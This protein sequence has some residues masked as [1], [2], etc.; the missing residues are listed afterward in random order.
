MWFFVT[1][2]DHSGSIPVSVKKSI[3]IWATSWQNQQNDCASSEDSDQS[4]QS[5]RCL[6]A[7]T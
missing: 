5:L 2:E 3:I 6:H 4:G 7:E 1:V